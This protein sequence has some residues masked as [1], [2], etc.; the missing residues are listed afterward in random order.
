MLK[1][2][3]ISV[4]VKTFSHA[5]LWGSIFEKTEYDSIIVNSEP[6]FPSDPDFSASSH[7]GRRRAERWPGT[8]EW[9]KLLDDGPRIID[10]KKRK[11]HY[12]L[13]QK[14]YLKES[15]SIPLYGMVDLVAKKKG[16]AGY[17]NNPNCGDIGRFVREWYWT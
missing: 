4:E 15:F 17:K 3:G 8:P 5:V 16:L 13:M 6:D 11:E 9:D 1:D 7:T 2:I 14:E 12:A 10:R